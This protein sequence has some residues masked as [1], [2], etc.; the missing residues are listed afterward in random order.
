MKGGQARHGG[1]IGIAAGIDQQVGR[2][3]QRPLLGVRADAVQLL[4]FGEDA[5]DG[6][7]VDRANARI[8]QQG[9]CAIAPG[10][11]FVH[12]GVGFSVA[13]GISQAAACAHGGDEC[14]DKAEHQFF[15]R[16][17]R[18]RP[19]RVQAADRP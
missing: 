13:N 16:A 10:Q 5:C 15:R 2:H 18:A 1:E 11:G 9:I 8:G 4:A 14:I 17:A 6:G 7:V 12:E 19:G 3:L